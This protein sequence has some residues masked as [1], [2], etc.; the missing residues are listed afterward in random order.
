MRHFFAPSGG[1]RD[2]R[3]GLG[4]DQRDP[5]RVCFVEMV[6]SPRFLGN[7]HE[8]ALLSDPGGTNVLRPI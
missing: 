1:W 8:R 2:L 4:I 3:R 7:P 6:G 5:S